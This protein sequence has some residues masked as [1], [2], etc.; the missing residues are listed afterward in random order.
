MAYKY[1]AFIACMVHLLIITC[2]LA[3]SDLDVSYAVIGCVLA[4]GVVLTVA[5]GKEQVV[6]SAWGRTSLE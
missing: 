5:G 2:V 4:R 6:M 1:R 3:A